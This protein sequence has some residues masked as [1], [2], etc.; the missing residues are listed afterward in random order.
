MSVGKTITSPT[1]NYVY[2][3]VEELGKGTYGRVY[4]AHCEKNGTTN[5]LV[6]KQ[7]FLEGMTDEDKE[8]TLNEVIFKS[9]FIKFI[10]I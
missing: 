6:L 7:V 5:V 10:T 2:E 4:K 9:F 8:E 1:T 3:I